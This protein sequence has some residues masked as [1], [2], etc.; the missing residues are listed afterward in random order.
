MKLIQNSGESPKEIEAEVLN[1][2]NKNFTFTPIA[3]QGFITN[4][5][6][7]FIKETNLLEDNADLRS[8]INTADLKNQFEDGAPIRLEDLKIGLNVYMEPRGE[9]VLANGDT[10]MEFTYTFNRN[11]TGVGN[12]IRDNNGK[13]IVNRVVIT[14]DKAKRLSTAELR[15]LKLRV[16]APQSELNILGSAISPAGLGPM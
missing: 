5:Q 9:G 1:N 3:S 6:L 14:A 11:G 8:L 13:M 12:P 10:F 15:Q 2:I 7:I 16:D 4:Q